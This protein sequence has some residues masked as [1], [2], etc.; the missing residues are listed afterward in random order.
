MPVWLMIAFGSVP[1]SV[2]LFVAIW[3]M[4]AMHNE[5]KNMGDRLEPLDQ[6]GKDIAYLKGRQDGSDVERMTPTMHTRRRPKIASL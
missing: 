5:L 3:R 6:M 1:G 2:A 4:G